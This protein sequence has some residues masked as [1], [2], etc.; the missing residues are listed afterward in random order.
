MSL[1]PKIGD[2]AGRRIWVV[3]ASSGIGHALA[4]N[5]L[6]NGA[7]V[8][9]SARNT[10]PLDKLAT[11]HPEQALVLALDVTDSAG[12][13]TAYETITARWQGI[14]HFIFCAADYQPMRAWELDVRKAQ[15]MV[16]TNLMGVIH[17]VATVLPDMLQRQQGSISMIASVAGYMGLP[18]SLI[19]GPTKAAMINFAEALYV[20][21]HQKGIAVS[22]INPGFVDTPLTRDNNFT[23]PALLTPEQATAE[24]ISG[25]E[26]GEFEIHFPK[27]FTHWL[28]MVRRLPYFLKFRIIAEVANRS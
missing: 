23:M 2:W 27:R 11:S 22:V 25:L 13:L 26:D 7:R 21:V 16:N 1:N 28:R 12:W 10:D 17:G 18:K 5:L 9:I 19:Y 24:I 15:N 6:M 8:V 4:H 14:D 20:D 3:G